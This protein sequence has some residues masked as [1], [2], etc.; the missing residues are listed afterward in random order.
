MVPRQVLDGTRVKRL[1]RDDRI[2]GVPVAAPGI[3]VL[4]MQAPDLRTAPGRATKAGVTYL[5]RRHTDLR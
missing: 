2:G 3:D 4:G 5:T 1:S